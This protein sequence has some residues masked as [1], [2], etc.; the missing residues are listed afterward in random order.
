LT[1]PAG[2]RSDFITA[3]IE[4]EQGRAPG[5]ALREGQRS[6]APLASHDGHQLSVFV[7]VGRQEVELHLRMK[8]SSLALRTK[9]TRWL[10]VDCGAL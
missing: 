8:A 1:P 4:L 9:R 7:V 10:R 5:A 2:S 3:S 6:H